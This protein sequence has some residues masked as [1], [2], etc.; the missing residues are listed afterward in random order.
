M[1]PLNKNAIIELWNRENKN[2]ILDNEILEYMIVK[3]FMPLFTK[4]WDTEDLTGTLKY[5]A[6]DLKIVEKIEPCIKRNNNKID[7]MYDEG[8]AIIYYFFRCFKNESEITIPIILEIIDS[9][10][11]ET[12]VE[13]LFQPYIKIINDH[14]PKPKALV[15]PMIPEENI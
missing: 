12:K 14:R 5:H 9:L 4:L 2:K 11:S 3:L 1:D 10:K 15:I 8:T 13:Y 7:A 6:K